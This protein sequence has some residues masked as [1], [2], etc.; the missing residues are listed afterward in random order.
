MV[1]CPPQGGEEV[2][3][4]R[5]SPLLLP[6]KKSGLLLESVFV[7]PQLPTVDQFRRPI[8]WRTWRIWCLSLSTSSR[9]SDSRQA[10]GTCNR[11]P[12]FSKVYR[13]RDI[14]RCFHGVNLK[15]DSFAPET[16]ISNGKLCSH[17]RCCC[18]TAIPIS[19]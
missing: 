2:G 15:K 13:H 19:I 10:D 9:T 17:P 1:G 12:P 16:E 6:T 18:K 5:L 3:V 8:D 4:C 7:Y 11:L 14:G